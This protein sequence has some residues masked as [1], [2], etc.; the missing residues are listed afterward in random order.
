MT[1]SI[2]TVTLNSD[3]TLSDTLESVSRQKCVS[4]QHIIKDGGSTDG[5]LEL[6]RNFSSQ[7]RVIEQGDIGIYDAMNQGFAS[8]TGDYVGFLNSDDF[9][10]YDTVLQDVEEIFVRDGVD[11]VYGD[12]EIINA[13]GTVVRQWRSGHLRDGRLRGKQIPHPA[14]FVRRKTLQQLGK[15]FDDSYQ[16]SADFKQQIQLIN[17]M[18]ATATYLSKTFVTMRHGGASSASLSAV[19]KGWRECMRAY[20]EVTGKPGRGFVLGKVARKIMQLLPWF[21]SR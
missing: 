2:I 14:F 20:E 17:E 21:R 5:T 16:I 10:S 4:V 11:I 3:E 8:A 19:S 9:L 13:S 1:F 12:I 18:G 6:A 7:V 15:P